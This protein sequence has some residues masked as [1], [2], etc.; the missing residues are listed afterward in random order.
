MIGVV[1]E[2]TE[3]LWAANE[4]NAFW[5][6]LEEMQRWEELQQFYGVVGAT[7]MLNELLINDLRL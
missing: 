7:R 5:M 6:D 4:A 2:L 3:N 1:G